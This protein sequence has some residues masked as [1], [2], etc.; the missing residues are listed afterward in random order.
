MSLNIDAAIDRAL[1]RIDQAAVTQLAVDLVSIPSPT[2]SERAGASFLAEHMAA[3]GPEPLAPRRPGAARARWGGGGGGDP[4]PGGGWR[5]RRAG[6][7]P[8]RL[9]FN[10]H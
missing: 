1:A 7:S 8:P 5:L 9:M 4:R 10:G 6:A 3:G 2:G